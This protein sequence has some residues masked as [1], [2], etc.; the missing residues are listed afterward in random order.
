MHVTSMFRVRFAIGLA[1]LI[2]MLVPEL[3]RADEKA[4]CAQAGNDAL[5]KKL[6]DL[7]RY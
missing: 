6:E 1:I 5:I 3:A 2:A 7:S 4:E